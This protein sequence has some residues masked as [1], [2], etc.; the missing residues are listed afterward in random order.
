MQ[1]ITK[2]TTK[3]R[4][5]ETKARKKNRNTAAAQLY[6][7]FAG[8]AHTDLPILAVCQLLPL[9]SKTTQYFL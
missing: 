4:E 2:G 8:R 1:N 9:Q 6:E 7:P 5:E 3:K